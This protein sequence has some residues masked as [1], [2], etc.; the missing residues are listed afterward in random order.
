MNEKKLAIFIV[1][2]KKPEKEI[3]MKDYH[4][5]G[6][7][8]NSH[9]LPY[10]YRDD[11]DE[12]IAMKN[13]TFC[14]LTVQYWIYKNVKADYVGLVHYRRFFFNPY[15]SIFKNKILS[16]KK[17]KKILSECDLIVPSPSKV[18]DMHATNVYDHYCYQHYKRDIDEV[19]KIILEKYP[20]YHEAFNHLKETDEYS[21]CNMM[22]AKKE[23]Y[24]DYSSF[25]FGILFELEKRIDISSYN[26][27]QKR[28]F[29]F[30]G[31]RL[32]NVYLWKHKELKIK[33]ESVV[34][35][36]DKN[37]FLTYVKKVFRNLF[38]IPEKKI[39]EV[40]KK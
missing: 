38:H 39:E 12:N 40:P 18:L 11:M 32:M 36:D 27:Y 13:P 28:V 24:D 19:E 26:D 10:E 6:V 17:I 5:I 7:G 3:R 4:F 1:T 31:E 37:V 20:E 9:S 35:L 21:L 2:H 16:S 15:I 14:E 33:Y 34:L 23:I 8:K 30:L 22:I 25:L 29:G